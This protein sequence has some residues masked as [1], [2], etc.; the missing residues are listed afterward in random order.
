MLIYHFAFYSYQHLGGKRDEDD[1]IYARNIDADDSD[2]EVNSDDDRLGVILLTDRYINCGM[3]LL[4]TPSLCLMIFIPENYVENLC[5]TLRLALTFF[6]THNT[7]NELI[8]YW[9]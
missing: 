2:V 8:M 1:R 3:G 4:V 9:Q 7:T 6:I 5:R